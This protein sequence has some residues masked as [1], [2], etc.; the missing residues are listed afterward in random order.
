ML[1]R[2][3]RA[4]SSLLFHVCIQSLSLSIKF[5]LNLSDHTDRDNI[6]WKCHS[7]LFH[8]I[9]PFNM[10]YKFRIFVCHIWAFLCLNDRNR[11]STSPGCKQTTISRIHSDFRTSGPSHGGVRNRNV[12]SQ[13]IFKRNKILN[14][15]GCHIIKRWQV[16][17]FYQFSIS[18]QRGCY[19]ISQHQRSRKEVW[20][21][22]ADIA[23]AAGSL[24]SRS[25]G[26]VTESM[27]GRIPELTS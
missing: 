3:S 12:C 6:K 1:S 23:R 26:P 20:G 15:W 10:S 9:C 19:P 8:Y 27:L 7:A 5:R 13:R 16:M 14:W 25:V 2:H 11:Q 21:N 24:A 4:R 17:L 18:L 22:V